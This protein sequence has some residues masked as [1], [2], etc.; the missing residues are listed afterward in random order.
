[1]RPLAAVGVFI[2]LFDVSIDP[3]DVLQHAKDYLKETLHQ[4]GS[5]FDHVT[6][7]GVIRNGSKVIN[8]VIMVILVCARRE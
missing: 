8:E 5:G 2:L 7:K 1:M 3:A 4:T 6:G